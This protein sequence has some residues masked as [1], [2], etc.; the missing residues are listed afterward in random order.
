MQNDLFNESPT[1][2]NASSNVSSGDISFLDY[3]AYTRL[4]ERP[5]YSGNNSIFN[6]SN[7][8]NQNGNFFDDF[9]NL[10]STVKWKTLN[11]IY[12]I[13]GAFGGPTCIYP[14]KSCYVLGTSKGPILIFST[15]Q[16]ILNRLVPQI[17]GEPTSKHL[18]SPVLD[19]VVSADGTHLAASYQSGDIFLWNLNANTVELNAE[20]A[21]DG[22][23]KMAPSRAILQITNHRG[24][25]ING[26]GFIGS[27]H[28]ALIVSDNTGGVFYH[29]GFRTHLWSLT[30]SSKQ[31]LHISTGEKLLASQAAPEIQKREPLHMIAVLTT[32]RFAI[33]ST[34]PR[35]MTLMLEDLKS[36]GSREITSNSCLAWHENASKVAFSLNESAFVFEIKGVS[37]FSTQKTFTKIGEPALSLQW[38]TDDLLGILTVSHNFLMVDVNEDLR[39]VAKFDFLV[40]HLL[41]PPNKHVAVCDKKL[42]LLTNYGLKVGQLPSWSD[43]TLNHVQTGNYPGALKFIKS[44]LQEYMP[45]WPLL[46]LTQDFSKREQELEK[47]FYNLALA[48]LRF[49]ITHQ[50]ADLNKIYELFS[51]VLSTVDLFQDRQLK[52]EPM[53]AFLE[54]SMEFFSED[55]VDIF[56]EV[57]LNMVLEGSMNALPA[58]IFKP[59]LINFA[60]AEKLSILEDMIVMLD[61]R[62][63]D[64]DL[65]VKLCQKYGLFC[66]L[67]YI[68]NTIFDEY[69][70]PLVDAV[71]RINDKPEETFIFRTGEVGSVNTIFDYLS[72]VLTGRQFP[73][74]DLI[75]PMK[76]QI[77]AKVSLYHMLF[78]GTC[79]EWPPGSGKKL[80]TEADS[81]HEPAFPYFNLLINFNTARML[82]TLNEIF[83]D[84][85]LNEGYAE[86]GL[87]ENPP[88]QI[89][90]QYM[91]DV[92][93]D[94]M[95]KKESTRD[96]VLMGIFV[97]CN[98]AKYPQFIR[99]SSRALEDVIAT[100]CGVKDLQLTNDCQRALECLLS[101][102][103]P[104]NSERFIAELKELNFKRVLF[105]LYV[106]TKKFFD[107]LPLALSSEDTKTDYNQSFP[108]VIS[109]VLFGAR[110]DSLEHTR[111]VGLIRGHFESLVD[112]L[113]PKLAVEFF[114]KFDPGIHQSVVS[115]SCED[116]QQ[117]YL[118]ELYSF[119]E[120]EGTEM[121]DLKDLYFE[122][123]CKYKSKQA[124]LQ[125]L[126]V[127]EFKNLDTE[128]ATNILLSAK[129]YEA[130]AVVHRRLQVNSMVVND[131]LNC[132]NDW[133]KVGDKQYATLNRYLN[134]AI[135]AIS[136]SSDDKLHNWTKL[137]ACFMKLYGSHKNDADVGQSCN[138]AFQELFVRLAMSEASA[139]G[140]KKGQFWSILTSALEH[141]EV[142]MMKAKD[143]RTLL[144]DVFTTYDIER[145]ISRLILEIVQESSVGVGQLYEST[146]T[147]GWPIENDECEICGKTLWGL[148]LDSINFVIWKNKRLLGESA[149]STS[150]NEDKAIVSFGCHHV[151]HKRCLRNLGQVSGKY[152]CLTCK[153]E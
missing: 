148:G 42:L 111:V 142:I 58:A 151:F 102:Y 137:I 29:S 16:F 108:T 2:S 6:E 75:M 136:D 105:I 112:K 152:S 33:I 146:L 113:G 99:L 71:S 92:V 119:G 19:I 98:V 91:V 10:S 76:R 45:L 120:L 18:R 1:T 28:T 56:F 85:L 82:S 68:C 12:P 139:N 153:K 73:K 106:K 93:L 89:T 38:I 59:M 64:I 84:S 122:L 79:V 3:R 40:H 101:T 95:K 140:D 96:K 123:S 114:Q 127:L 49:I 25:T 67:M 70:L 65:A 88:V 32:S 150:T 8:T 62:T 21:N 46:R 118:E 41:M 24:R 87:G 39:V 125:W 131:M 34:T 26:I 5:V 132:I 11:K 54:K 109:F 116:T 144:F 117:K 130:A 86:N 83:E 14:T 80:H 66:V 97:A 35:P 17:V 37:T 60:D 61:L 143:L 121:N 104:K 30:Y 7:D 78:S 124:L 51:L 147:K 57:L 47:P 27:R 9:N 15:K 103:T 128:R 149:P 23:E 74:S 69:V 90:R 72:F 115:L 135:D 36:I 20:E 52:I 100:I 22:N 63:L 44:L 145:H 53:N 133:F 48:A 81:A 107:I 141:Q 31:V 77:D 126:G 55:N 43:I 134:I 129:N 138:R 4:S 13:L 94:M 50:N 110:Y